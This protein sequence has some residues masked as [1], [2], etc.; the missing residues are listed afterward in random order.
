MW[1]EFGIAKHYGLQRELNDKKIEL[2]ALRDEVTGIEREIDRWKKDSFYLEKM[3]R[4]EL[5]LG[6]KGEVVYLYPS[7]MQNQPSPRS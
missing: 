4:E 3:A 5:G 6:G 2:L 7:R 1:G